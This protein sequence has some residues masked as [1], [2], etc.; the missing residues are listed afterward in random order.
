M[1]IFTAIPLPQEIKDRFAKL[2][3]GRLSIPYVNTSQFHIT[4]NFLGE[5]DS[6]K[7]AQV[8]NEWTHG[9]VDIK[10]FQVEFMELVK[11][12]QQIHMT[13]KPSDELLNLQNIMKQNFFDMGLRP[14]HPKYYPHVTIGNLHMDKVMYKDGKVES[15]PHNTLADLT[16][17][18]EKIVL[19]VSKLLLHHHNHQVM[20][21]LNLNEN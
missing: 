2:A 3:Q 13:V 20:D 4:L 8:K 1:R 21:E 16:F 11:F 17:T 6:D 5:L 15:F 18:V 12:R 9:L 14:N 7:L 19:F 10:R